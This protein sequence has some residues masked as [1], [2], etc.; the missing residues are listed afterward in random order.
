M[1][2][3]QCINEIEWTKSITVENL[4]LQCLHSNDMKKLTQVFYLKISDS[5]NYMNEIIQ[6]PF[7]KASDKKLFDLWKTFTW[8]NISLQCLHSNDIKS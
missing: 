6:W 2:E 1:N 4:S 7:E 8:E 3:M 5:I